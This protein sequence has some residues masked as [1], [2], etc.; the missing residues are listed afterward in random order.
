MGEQKRWDVRVEGDTVVVEL[1]RRLVLDDRASERLY[2][3]I[4]T[5]V[6]G[7]IDRVLTVVDVEHPL[8]DT[9]HD[10]VVR[11]AR[12]AAAEGVTDWHVTGEHEHKAAA[13][14]RELP[15]VET[16]VFA[17]VREARAQPA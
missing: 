13:V 9:L 5:A 14:A 8:S 6:T 2:S 16:A 7:D 15:S 3:A 11:G 12:T 1:R 10:A 17:D 4:E